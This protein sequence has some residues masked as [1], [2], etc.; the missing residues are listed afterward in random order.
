MHWKLGPV[1][2]VVLNQWLYHEERE[3]P[4]GELQGPSIP[5]PDSLSPV[6]ALL[7]ARIQTFTLSPLLPP[8]THRELLMC[9]LGPPKIDR[10]LQKAI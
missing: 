10:G 8:P 3:E 5:L 7:G 1:P 4:K 9:S 6:M 2:R